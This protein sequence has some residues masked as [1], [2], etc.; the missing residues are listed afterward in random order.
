[1][2]PADTLTTLFN[3]NL[4]ANLRLLEQCAKLTSEQLDATLS[5]GYGSI[6]ALG[7]ASDIIQHDE[8]TFVCSSKPRNLGE[9]L[10]VHL[11]H[12]LFHFVTHFWKEPV[13]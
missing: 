10:I 2:N 4:W 7:S 3:H 12:L 6:H 9:G 8:R 5:G 1:M 11:S 13:R